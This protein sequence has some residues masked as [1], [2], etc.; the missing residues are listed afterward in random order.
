[1]GHFFSRSCD[2]KLFLFV[3]IIAFLLMSVIEMLKLKQTNA[4]F[5]AFKEKNTDTL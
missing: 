5:F 3:K 1:M 4:K 2:F